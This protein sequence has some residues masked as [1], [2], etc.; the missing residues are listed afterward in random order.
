MLKAEADKRPV[1]SIEKPIALAAVKLVYPLPDHETGTVRDVIVKKLINGPIFYDRHTGRKQWSRIIPGLDVKIPWPKVEPKEQKDFDADTLRVDVEAKTFVP[2][3]LKQPMPGSVIDELRN[4]FSK[5]RTRHDE[6]YIEAKL[7]E[8]EEAIKKKQLAAEMRTP[9]NELNRKIRKEKKAKGKPVL[10][11]EMLIRIGETIAKKR[12][13]AGF[14][15]EA[16]T[17]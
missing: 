4:K 10:S 12:D 9:L 15:K 8:D 3:L 2:S 17:A 6:S 14:E 5:F 1:R 16:I 7:K 11:R 13:A